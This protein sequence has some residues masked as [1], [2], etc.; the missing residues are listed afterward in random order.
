MHIIA[1]IVGAIGFILVWYWRLKQLGNVAKDGQKVLESVA[2][3]P[4]KMRFKQR[5]GKGGLDVVDDP[6]EAATIIM[7][8]VAQARSALTAKQSQ[9][10][11][12]HIM[13]LFEFDAADA[14]ELVAQAAWLS[15]DGGATHIV[16]RKM[17]TFI[18]KAPGMGNDEFSNLDRALVEI[19]G[20]HGDATADQIDLIETYR[21]KTM[22]RH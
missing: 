2:N 11:R 4:R 1:I 5:S 10:I 8:E 14:E 3:L 7:L 12:G 16:V 17:A 22:L 21:N 6:R 19:A 18:S 9:I 20:C 15:R 13:R